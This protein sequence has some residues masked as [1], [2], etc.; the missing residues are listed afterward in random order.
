[1]TVIGAGVLLV[2]AI[3]LN[4][5]FVRGKPV[6]APVASPPGPVAPTGGGVPGDAGGL[7]P[8]APGTGPAYARLAVFGEAAG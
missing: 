4:F 7:A 8:V 3:L 2:F 1:V 5:V 6:L